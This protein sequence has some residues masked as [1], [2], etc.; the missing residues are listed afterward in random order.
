MMVNFWLLKLVRSTF[1]EH[2]ESCFWGNFHNF[3]AWKLDPYIKIS[4]LLDKL[5]EI[6][7]YYLYV[8]SYFSYQFLILMRV[9]YCNLPLALTQRAS[10]WKLRPEILHD[11]VEDGSTG[12]A[13]IQNFH[14][15][16]KSQ[17]AVKFIKNLPQIIWSWIIL[18]AKIKC[19]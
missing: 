14:D 7:K 11:T 15:F 16:A 2:Y 4:L 12:G 18:G 1:F 8:Q 19:S 10:Y 17:I 6:R 9:E 3:K 5:V 13:W